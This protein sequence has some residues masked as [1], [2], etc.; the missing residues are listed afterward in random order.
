VRVSPHGRIKGAVIRE[1]VLWCEQHDDRAR[2]QRVL[3]ALER[4][5]P[6]AIDATR[7]GA[8][9]LASQ[10]Y[11]AELVHVM[12]DAIIEGRA[13][14]ELDA[15]ARAA[16][17]GYYHPGQSATLRLG[18]NILAQ[19][20]TIHPKV[21][22][23]LDVKGSAVGFEIFLDRLPS[24]RAKG[25]ARPLLNASALQPLERDFAFIVDANVPAEKLVKAA[26]GADKALV[27]EV[28]LFDLFQGGSLPEGKKS[29]A[30]SVTLQPREKT[31]TDAEIEAL[32]AK[33]VAA[34]NKATG[35]EL[36]K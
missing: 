32:S 36:R 19:F 8:G 26:K 15:M 11:P 35:G 10:W 27:T 31:L 7:P 22:Q 28:K 33:V 12:I 4:A 5:Y 24:P 9:L 18:P 1:F 6:D 21:A 25:T 34:V 13:Q 17:P 20:G 14:E 23:A 3:R 29:L 16:A 2:L 30:L